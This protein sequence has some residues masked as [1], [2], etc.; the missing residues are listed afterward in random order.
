MKYR[1]LVAALLLVGCVPITPLVSDYN[2]ASVKIEFNDFGTDADHLAAAAPEALRICR[3]GGKRR[4]E[5]ASTT[6]NAQTYSSTLLFL[7]LN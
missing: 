7:C 2:G 1:P 3:A 4:A 6:Y 5:Y